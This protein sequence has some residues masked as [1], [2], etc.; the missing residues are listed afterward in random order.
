MPVNA[1]T[2]AECDEYS[3][4]CF[5]DGECIQLSTSGRLTRLAMFL[6]LDE[7]L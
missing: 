2:K 1:T 7:V 3:D 6:S 4:C 5:K